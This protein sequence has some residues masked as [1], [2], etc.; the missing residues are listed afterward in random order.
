MTS[1]VTRR[2]LLMLV[3]LGVAAAGGLA[4]WR[5]LDR[6]GTGK[7]DPHD[8]GNPMLNRPV[9][10]FALGGIAGAQ[11]FSTDD[12][13]RAAAEKPVLVNFFWS[14]CVPCAMEADVIGRIA[15]NG[16]P[17]WGIAWKDK[18]DAIKGFL[19]RFGNP[20]KRIADDTNG[21]VSIDWGVYGFPESFLIDRNG[22]I[23]WH[24]AG[25]LTEESLESSLQPALQRIA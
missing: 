18:P 14:S 21:R 9:P 7:F 24:L 20:Y 8:I 25:P 19:D 5:M 1:E 10:G 6:M 15:S 16:T 23:R 3:P 22:V 12:L 11:G 2:R 4:F 13:R 17:V